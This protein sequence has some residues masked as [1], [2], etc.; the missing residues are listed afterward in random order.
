[1]LRGSLRV[2]DDACPFLFSMATHRSAY[3]VIRFVT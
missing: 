1:M 2:R 3:L